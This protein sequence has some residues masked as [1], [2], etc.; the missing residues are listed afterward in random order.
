MTQLKHAIFMNDLFDLPVFYP[1]KKI[2]G[3]LSFHVR[4]LFHLN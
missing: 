4:F 1:Y 2:S 3:K